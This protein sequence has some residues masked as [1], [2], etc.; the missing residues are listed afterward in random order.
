MRAAHRGRRPSGVR[1]LASAACLAALTLAG[2]SVIAEP[3]TAITTA[4]PISAAP[5]P[6]GTVFISDI[7]NNRIVEVPGD[8]SAQVVLGSGLSTPQDIALDDAG[9][10]YIADY[11]NNRV[12]KVP[13]DGS[14]QVTVGAID[15]PI[16]ID[17]DAAGNVY[18]ANDWAVTMLPADGSPQSQTRG[19]GSW[20][21]DV[22]VDAAGNLYI[23]QGYNDVKVYRVP[24]DGSPVTTIG[25]TVSGRPTAVDVTPAGDVYIADY[26]RVIKV[27]ADGGAQTTVHPGSSSI[28]LDVAVDTGGNVFLS[29]YGD[30]QT[31]E[32]PIDGGA[33]S[34]V[35]AGLGKPSGV[36]VWG[37][38]RVRPAQTITF[39]SIP[40]ESPAFG[41]TYNLTAVGGASGNPVTFAVDGATTNSACSLAG[42]TVTFDHAGA[43]VLS[44]NQADDADNAAAPTVRQTVSVP[45]IAQQITFTS[46]PPVDAHIG[47]E[48]EPT[49][50]GGGSGNWVRFT[51]YGYPW[52]GAACTMGW[53]W[54]TVTFTHAGQCVIYAEQSGDADH[55]DAEMV[56]QLVT[57]APSP[58]TV[59]FTSN[60]TSTVLGTT[61]TAAAS[62]GDSG[63]PVTFSVDASTTNLACTVA[64]SVVSFTHAGDCVLNAD[65]AGGGDYD[66]APTVQQ[67]I[68]LGKVASDATLAV[69]ATNLTAGITSRAPGSVVPTGTVTF[70][71]AGIEVG[72]AQTV[73]GVATLAYSVP[74]GATRHVEATYAGNGDFTGSSASVDRSDPSIIATLTGTPARSPYGWYRSTVTV[75]FACTPAGAALTRVCPDSVNVTREGADQTVTRTI[76]A[77]DGGA[78][79]VVA[80]PINIDRTKPTVAIAGIPHRGSGFSGTAKPRCVGRDALS[81][82]ARCTVT[83][84]TLRGV[85]W[86]VV[87]ATDR[88]GNTMRRSGLYRPIAG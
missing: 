86:Y 81:G 69:G 39:T 35:G 43:C 6:T 51:V 60:P 58:Q 40:P 34:V 30:G 80:G 18:V 9:N 29:D 5:Y 63:L 25:Q 42:S 76:R 31:L 3:A 84:H 1:R 46:A 83:L 82:V 56:Y 72:S 33:T 37:S 88:A 52:W 7:E 65:E 28:I 19:S 64:G 50:T 66:A 87:R 73:D 12:V 74:T 2:L 44:A 15:R 67:T 61:Y 78:A 11:Y 36:A 32:E 27:P 54:N 38:A 8:G 20:S 41:A 57:V 21:R 59:S 10:L 85:T 14:P 48:Y 13:A 77:T 70:T 23:V 47:D 68:T 17:V 62:G 26:F 45:Q 22:A 79:T 49:A 4:A 24:A 53:R 55:S 16:G 71:V 75:T